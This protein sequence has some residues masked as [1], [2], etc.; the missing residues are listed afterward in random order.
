MIDVG[1]MGD[2]EP[3]PSNQKRPREA[4]YETN[5]EDDNA[6]SHPNLKKLRWYV[7]VSDSESKSDEL[8]YDKGKHS[9]YI[10]GRKGSTSVGFNPFGDMGYPFKN[11]ER[12]HKEQLQRARE[13]ATRHP[14]KE[15]A[16]STGSN[17]RKVG[18]LLED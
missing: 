7:I 17:S 11:L 4:D 6:R 3:R 14:A 12:A 10:S 16:E 9:N 8:E 1:K 5:D 18:E 15:G 2:N 13:E